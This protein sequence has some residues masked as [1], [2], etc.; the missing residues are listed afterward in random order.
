MARKKKTAVTAPAA[1]ETVAELRKQ[2]AA[3]E[4]RGAILQVAQ[5][6]LIALAPHLAGVQQRHQAG[7]IDD[8]Q[9]ERLHATIDA[10][11]ES[12]GSIT[13]AVLLLNSTLIKEKIQAAPDSYLG[14]VLRTEAPLDFDQ[15]TDKLFLRFL[16]RRPTEQERLLSLDL[17]AKKGLRKGGEDLQW[18]LVNKVEFVHNN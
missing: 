5:L 7:C 9:L 3:S 14:S 18:G 15:L 17:L 11:P 12:Q 2:L 10:H 16:M 6:D 13:Q 1:D 4:K 8:R